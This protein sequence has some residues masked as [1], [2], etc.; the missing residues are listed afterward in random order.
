MLSHHESKGE[1]ESP[2]WI[3]CMTSL[4]TY[5]LADAGFTSSDVLLIPYRNVQYHL[6]EW[7]C[8]KDG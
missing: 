8:A 5:Y 7:D 2:L 1:N 4:V 6:L 3:M